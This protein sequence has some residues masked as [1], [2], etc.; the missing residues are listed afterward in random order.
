M[1][2]LGQSAVVGEDGVDLGAGLA[3]VG[4]GG[5][6]GSATSM[7]VRPARTS[8]QRAAASRAP[9]GR[10]R[11]RRR[12]PRPRRASGVSASARAPASSGSRAAR[13]GRGHPG[14]V[15]PEPGEALGQPGRGGARPWSAARSASATR[16][17][18]AP[19]DRSC[20][21]SMAANRVPASPGARRAQARAEIAATGL[22][23]CGI[24]DEPPRR[25]ALAD[26]ADLGLGQQHDVDGD[27]R[28]HPRRRAEH[29]GEVRDREAD[30]VPGRRGVGEAQLGR[31]TPSAARHRSRRWRRACPP[32]RRTAPAGRPPPRPA[33]AARRRARRASPAA[34]SPKVVG[35]ACC[36]RVRPMT[37]SSRWAAA[38]RAAA[39]AAAA[40]SAS[41][42][43]MALRASS[44]R[45][46]S[47]MS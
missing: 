15:R 43:A 34:F 3:R 29:A 7:S 6:A 8:R 11:P 19:A 2:S 4:S 31:R 44:T 22:C 36:I 27:R 1:G 38:R 5:R 46:V 9:A 17:C 30:G 12:A 32:P 24:A 35:S 20:S 45:A 33:A 21:C 14:G 25:P 41:I 18:Q 16:L 47:R 39:S 40:R 26:L 13:H 42:A 23:L 28:D 37:T 10:P